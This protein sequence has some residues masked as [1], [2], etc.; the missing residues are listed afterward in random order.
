[1]RLFAADVSLQYMVFN[2][3]VVLLCN[4]WERQQSGLSVDLKKETE[5]VYK[6]MAILR[7]FES[8]CVA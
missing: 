5:D 7:N 4:I 1:M 6:C 3:A 8:R 2:A